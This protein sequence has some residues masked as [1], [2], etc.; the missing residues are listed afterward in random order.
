[1]VF[2]WRTASTSILVLFVAIFTFTFPIKVTEVKQ[3]VISH[4]LSL[5][6]LQAPLN[7]AFAPVVDLGY[8]KYQ[9]TI[10]PLTQNW[11]FLGIRYAAEPT[12]ALRFNAPAP[13]PS[14]SGTQKANAYPVR[15]FQGGIGM[16]PVNPVSK[17]AGG[18][19]YQNSEF[20]HADDESEDCLFLNVHT[21][22]YIPMGALYGGP[23]QGFYDGNSL[24]THSGNGV[25]VVTVQYRL[26]VFGFLAGDEVKRQQ[27]AFQWVQEHISKFGGDPTKVTIWGQSAGAGS[28]L[29]HLIANGGQ[30]NPPLFRA[31]IINSVFLPS[32]YVY[33]DP[34]PKAIYT[35][36]VSQANCSSSSDTLECLRNAEVTV[37][38]TAHKSIGRA[39]FFGTFIPV[40]VVDGTFITQSPLKALKAGKLNT[41]NLLAFSTTDEGSF[42]V[43]RDIVNALSH[44]SEYPRR[45]A[46]GAHYKSFG[47]NVAT[48]R[49][50]MGDALFDCPT[51][52]IL[53]N[54]VGA[55]YKAS[56]W[57]FILFAISPGFHGNDIAYLFP[58]F[59]GAGV[60][61][62]NNA[63]FIKALT[64]SFTN[65]VIT[66]DPNDNASTLAPFWHR[67]NSESELSEISF[68]ATESGAPLVQ[69]VVT[70]PGL[71]ER[72]RFWESVT[73]ETFQ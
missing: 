39:T 54:F 58:K 12:G 36:V 70:D 30:T 26:G 11:N 37:L 55:A 72:C 67:W 22:N 15:C 42:F 43:H 66:L 5:E 23:I 62:Y 57:C 18:F 65:F 17:N 34:I 28:V 69:R 52:Y 24:I 60:P 13:P 59:T 53:Q 47:D 68:N 32:Q 40:P 21:P 4:I 71:L 51:Y 48:A 50:I 44:T 10:D 31:A 1:M 49:K 3:A 41:N 2:S 33:N 6:A 19:K 63:E 25:I 45:K 9:G 27:F 73:G 61:L 38:A 35:E 29:Q 20:I 46:A 64:T 16:S 56:W 14:V 8:A 7:A